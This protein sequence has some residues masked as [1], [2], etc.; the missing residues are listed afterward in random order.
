[1]IRHKELTAD[2]PRLLGWGGAGEES[3]ER[4]SQ[5]RLVARMLTARWRLIAAFVAAGVVV[6]AVVTLLTERRYTATS[7]VHVENS[8]PQV[9]KIDQVAAA[10]SYLEGVEYFQ[11]QVSLLKS[12]TLMAAVI[13]ELGLQDDAR[14]K[15]KPPGLAARAVGAVMGLVVSLGGSAPP[16]SSRAGRARTACPAAPS[17]AT[18]RTST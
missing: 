15:P 13:R 5:A 2:S 14:F 18:R 3:A 9:T 10:P 16:P 6:M 4:V 8:A 12:R 7:V 17:I 11:D 1:M